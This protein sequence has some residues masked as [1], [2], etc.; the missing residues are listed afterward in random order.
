MNRVGTIPSPYGVPLKVFHD[1]ARSPEPDDCFFHDADDCMTMAGIHNPADRQRCFAAMKELMGRGGMPFQVFLDHGGR[2]IPR[3]PLVQ[4]LVKAYD[5]LRDIVGSGDGRT[6]VENWAT[7]CLDHTDWAARAKAMLE[8]ISA[9][10]KEMKS[11]QAPSWV[12]A[13]SLAKLATGGMEHLAEEEIDCLEAASFYAISAHQQWRSAGVRWLA[14]FKDT[15]FADWIKT[16]PVYRRH[17]SDCREAF[18]EL[19]AWI[20]GKG[21]AL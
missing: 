9:A 13:L 7:L 21:G 11:W 19:P 6:P 2:K 15:W 1:P 20:C 3:E 18:A 8:A 12:G 16:R 10:R 14:P 5:E 4:P 17:A